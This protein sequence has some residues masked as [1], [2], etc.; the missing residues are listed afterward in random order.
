MKKFIWAISLLL[1]LFTFST[2]V[3]A[4]SAINQDT[5]VL[6]RS[7]T[8]QGDLM[9]TG[10]RAVIEGTVEGDVY[11][12]AESVQILGTVQGDVIA[13]TGDTLINGTVEGNVRAFT[14]RLTVNGTIGRNI[15]VGSANLF[16]PDQANIKGSVYAFTDT[17]DLFGTIEK[18]FNGWVHNLR[19]TGTIGKGISALRADNI[20]MESS[21]AINGDLVYTSPQKALIEPGAKLAG[22]EKFTQYQPKKES[23]FNIP[24]VSLLV[25]LLST[26]LLW[27]IIRYL[28]PTALLRI[29][30]GMDTNIGSQLGVGALLLIG[31][32]LFAIVLMVTLVGIP[33]AIALAL[34]LGLLLY[35]SKIFVG[36]WAGMRLARQFRWRLHPLAAELIGILGIFILLQVPFLGWVFAIVIWMIFLG[37]LAAVVRRANEAAR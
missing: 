3:F 21:A 23:G 22:Q 31:A 8:H 28:F 29:Q 33:V 19:I 27:L 26:L 35:V 1:M 5:Y 25:S 32:P 30:Q 7:E 11:V 16:I 37:S 2:S 36:C 12:F 13:F 34:S 15:T 18:E 24:I 20:K 10:K 14:Q 6:M 4:F 9:I 17:V